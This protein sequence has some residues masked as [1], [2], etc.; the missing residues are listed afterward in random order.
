LV[1]PVD[2]LAIWRVSLLYV[3]GARAGRFHGGWIH[4]GGASELGAFQYSVWSLLR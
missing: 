3:D 4:V 1:Q 2:S